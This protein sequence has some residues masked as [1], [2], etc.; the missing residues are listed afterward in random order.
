MK[1]PTV[2]RCCCC[3]DLQL[4]GLILGWLG[5][6]SSS[7]AILDILAIGKT[8]EALTRLEQNIPVGIVIV[9][10]L[11]SLIM[12]ISWTYG[13]SQVKPNFLLAIIILNGIPLVISYISFFVSLPFLIYKF[14]SEGRPQFEDPHF[15]KMMYF[16]FVLSF[17][18]LALWTYCW[19][20]L[21]SIYRKV[22]ID[23][24]QLRKIVATTAV[25]VKM[26]VSNITP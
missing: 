4:G 11:V 7:W 1:I 15:A 5:I 12:N 13:I 10:Y 9:G 19:I 22:K 21:Y 17:V 18:L 3:I 6:I 14:I 23:A 8:R 16:I 24:Q 2:S 25:G 20:V 26:D